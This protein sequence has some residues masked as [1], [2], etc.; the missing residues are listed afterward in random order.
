MLT[1]IF[2][3]GS[4]ALPRNPFRGS[5]N[6]SGTSIIRL[7]ALPSSQALALSRRKCVSIDRL[8]VFL[9]QFIEQLQGPPAH[10]ARERLIVLTGKS[11]GHFHIRRVLPIVTE[12]HDPKSLSVREK[13]GVPI[14]RHRKRIATSTKCE[15]NLQRSYLG[16]NELPHE[17]TVAY[18]LASP[19]G[20][21][22]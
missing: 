8:N 17:Y 22:F 13:A 5:L 11:V 4:L 19:I 6:L 12:K 21:H 15:T 7:H 10:G 20:N 14:Q 2:S 1:P 18:P 9:P 3:M 16:S